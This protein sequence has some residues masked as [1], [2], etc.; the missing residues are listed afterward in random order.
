MHFGKI[1]AESN[2]VSRESIIRALRQSNTAEGIAYAKMIKRG[3]INL[4]IE[5]SHRKGYGGLYIFGTNDIH[6]YTNVANTP[7]VAAGY[8]AHETTHYLQRLTRST[9][10]RRHEF[11]A[12]MVQRKV[13]KSFPL[14][15]E[16]AI[17][18]LI[19]TNSAYANV[20]Q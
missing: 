5:P 11:E 12:Y 15:T 9:Y 1:A 18:D 20:K 13:D 7:T 16:E 17:W 19:N 6:V 4:K 3:I 10:R 2:E 8:A 14:R